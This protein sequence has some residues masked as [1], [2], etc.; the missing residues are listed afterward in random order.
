VEAS[1]L[2]EALGPRATV[3]VFGDDPRGFAFLEDAA[4]WIGRDVLF[5]GRPDAFARGLKTA[6]P[7]FNRID[8]QAPVAVEIGNQIL[9]EAEVAIGRNLMSRYQLPYPRR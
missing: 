6:S 3:L 8:R 2:A 1:R 5:I 4:A 9:F 7:H